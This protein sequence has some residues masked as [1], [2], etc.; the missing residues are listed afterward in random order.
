MPPE[1]G[2]PG[3]PP[4]TTA[5]PPTRRRV[6][7]AAAEV[8]SSDGLDASMEA[9]AE[10]AGVTRMTVYR[11]LGPRDQ[12]L[13]AVLLD[14]AAALADRLRPVLAESCRPFAE[15]IVDSIVLVVMTVRS[16][17][18]LT[19][20]VQG[21]TPTQIGR[22]DRDDRFVDQVSMLLLP[23]FDEA[24]ARGELRQAPAATV[25]WT[26]RQ[27]LLQLVVPYTAG[28]SANDLRDELWRFFVP[29]I[30]AGA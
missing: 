2:P 19:F 21:L 5:A 18:V 15:R 17:T 27:I 25:E 16:S 8:L 26:L 22:L 6:L 12:L 30:I 14:Q 29:S 7:D 3:A 13:V 9:I 11:V 4:V 1:P 10:R 20:F 23:Y 24:G 28:A